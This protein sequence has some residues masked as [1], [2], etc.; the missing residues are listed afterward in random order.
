MR[1][2]IEASAMMPF[3]LLAFQRGA[4]DSNRERASVPPQGAL[5]LVDPLAAG[6]APQ[7]GSIARW[8]GGVRG[9]GGCAS[10]GGGEG[11][12]AEGA[13]PG[14]RLVYRMLKYGRASAKQGM[15]EYAAKMQATAERVL[16]KKAAA[17]G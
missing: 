1:S 11:A 4:P 10:P 15:D 3:L 9:G 2:L 5:V 13:V 7:V 8:W 14:P 17:L 12:E 6:P 16:R